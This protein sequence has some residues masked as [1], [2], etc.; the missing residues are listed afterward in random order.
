MWPGQSRYHYLDLAPEVMERHG[1]RWTRDELLHW[2]A[3]SCFAQD[4]LYTVLLIVA[5]A[6][7]LFGIVFV[8]IRSS[9]ML[10]SVLPIGGG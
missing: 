8:A 4:D 3:D 9:Q 5:S 1:H 2:G 7:L 6:I 10:G